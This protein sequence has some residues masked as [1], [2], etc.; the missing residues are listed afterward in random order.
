MEKLSPSKQETTI[1]NGFNSSEISNGYQDLAFGM[2]GGGFSFTTQLSKADTQYLNLRYYLVSND[3]NL[4]SQMYV[5]H[6]IIQTLIDQPVDDAF[7]GGFEIKT[8]QLSADEIKELQ[9]YLKKNRVIPA[10]TDAL[11]W[12]R[13]YGGS[14]IVLNMGQDYQTELDIEK[15]NK[16]GS[17]E[18]IAADL[19]ELT[20]NNPNPDGRGGFHEP[21]Y[22]NYYGLRLH[23]SRVYKI[24]GKKAPSFVR[25]R[26]RGWGMSEVEKMIRS[27]N[28]YMKNQNVIFELL[29]EAKID[30]YK[31]EG[32]NSTL[33]SKDGTQLV[34]NRIQASNMM[35]NFQNALLM[36]KSDEYEQKSMNFSGLGEM[37]K[38]IREGIAADLKIPVT[39]L[40]GIS[41]AGF[42]SGED[43]IENYNSM[44]E[45]EIR[46]KVEFIVV[47]IL[48]ICCQHLFGYVPEDLEIEFPP[49]RMMST[50]QEELAKTNQY[51]RIVSSYQNGLINGLEAQD[52]INAA[53]LLPLQIEADGDVDD[54]LE[55]TTER[56][57]YT[58]T[59]SSVEG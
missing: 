20:G 13:L 21:E 17:L 22:Y 47:D 50:E 9:V 29:D 4:L 57:D 2:A 53:D 31:M 42:N 15:I 43:D 54:P 59:D 46:A 39:K 7:R 1:S 23:N 6:G 18:F 19:W 14:G 51:N 24:L 27:V 37:L 48:R 45:S 40:F 26:L 58:V 33:M 41:S 30:V 16:G 5:E 12:S 25:A 34:Q 32:M 44:I 11:K 38:Q 56:S 10:I 8:N 49:L 3:R 36:D 55:T 28:Q 35:K 52:A